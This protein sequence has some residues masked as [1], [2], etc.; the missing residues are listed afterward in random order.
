[1]KKFLMFSIACLFVSVSAFAQTKT[2]TGKIIG[3]DDGLGLPASV[4]VQG[5]TRGV[6]ADIDGNYSIA[7]DRGQTLVISAI[8]YT[9]QEIVIGDANVID[10]TLQVEAAQLTEAVVTALGIR[11]EKKALGYSVQDIKS[12]EL[13]KNKT[14]NP[15]NSLAGKV[16]GVNVTQSSGAAGS[17]AQI[18]LRGGTS[19]DE[20][21]DNQ[22]LFVVDGMI[23]DNST[24]V[25][26]SSGFDGMTGTATTNSNRIMDIN[27]EDIENMSIL[28]GPAAAA[29]Y[30]S[31]AAN[32]VI[33]ITTKKGAEGTVSVD[34]SSKFSTAWANRLPEQ[35]ST[36]GRGSYQVSGQLN[37]ND[38]VVYS[39]WGEKLGS[40]TTRYNNIEDFFQASTIF[41]NTVSVSGGS[42]TG[43]FY[44]SASNF[45]QKGIVPN[46][47][48]VKNTFR[49]N[50]EQKYGKLTLNVG[51]AYSQANTDKTLTSDGLYG[52]GGTGTM[53]AVYRWAR[54]ENMKTW[55]N[56]D[57][58]KYIFPQYL[59][60]NGQ[61]DMNQYPL[62]S[63]VENPYWLINKNK[64]TDQTNRFTGNATAD[65]KV[66]D[67]WNLTYR[68]G[69]DRYTTGNRN[70][71][72]P[73][74]ELT[75]ADYQDGL[76][77]ENQLDFQYLSYNF[78]SNMDKTFGDFS[79]GLLLGFSEEETK[80]EQNYRMAIRP[81]VDGF[82]SFS[83]STDENK[84]LSQ[85]QSKTRMRSFYGE[86]RASY[87]NIAYLTVTGRGD[88]N[89]TLY[90]PL[91][92]D[93]NASYFYPSVG[94]SFIFSEVLPDNLKSV[95]SF[96]KVRAS[97]AQVGKGTD[98]YATST[99][100]WPFTTF[101]GGLTGTANFWY[102]GNP[103]LKP[104]MT[105]SIE[106]GLEMRFL[107]GRLGFDYTYYSNKSTDLILNPRT[108]QATGYIFNYTNIGE[109]YNKGMELSITGQPLKT[110]DWTWDMAL[111]IAG[112]RGT[113]GEIHQSLPILYVTSVQVGRAK[114]ASY[115]NGV[116]MAISGSKWNRTDDGKV[117]LNQYG[118]PTHD[119]ATATA[120]TYYIGN[121]EPKFTGGFNNSIR[122]KGW[123]LSFLFEFR[124]GGDVY[125]G[126]ELWLTENGM[127]K[128]TEN[129]ETLTIDGVINT[130]TATDPVYENKT[131]TFNADQTY[132]MANGP[133][134]GKYII[135]QYWAS[136]YPRESAYFKTKTNWLRLRSV[137]LS[138]TLPQELLAK[139][140]FIKGCTVS[141]TGTNLLL[142]T[143]YKGL[144]PEASAAGSGIGGSSSVGIEYCNVPATAG[145]SFGINL[146][147]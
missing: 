8:G 98:P 90:S 38:Y 142:I 84:R 57:G 140:K 131:F 97:W 132:Q 48:Y 21:R 121:R 53:N 120:N 50:G 19:L 1:M 29:L 107:K 63:F 34:F 126:T 129:R 36:Y 47:G 109:V 26:G 28:K 51:A 65:F 62:G 61:R 12:E 96:G 32:G 119:D 54:N 44:F 141:V 128:L 23:Y 45:D 74:G 88:K 81:S 4:Q 127:S 94:G 117:I 6:S 15:L 104:E 69:I 52:S 100:L 31:R 110:K 125:N 91:T 17:G 144:D 103:Y 79:V 56:S 60:V 11:K 99:T 124:V 33:I 136:E 55:L 59:D 80:T 133:Q 137:S 75:K 13:L 111:N 18:I 49:F 134:S 2:V 146:K 73:G 22:P 118:M 108:S 83:V 37:P 112:N 25:V 68:A 105:T 43:S 14:A 58:S 95:I 139:V 16:A 35:Q 115:E 30:G 87:K 114:A 93:A 3:S 42:K 122:Y 145:L 27:P 67:W 147:F 39:S 130:G 64:M 77:S 82:P 66:F 89:S 86:V 20:S 70:I 7:V 113:V 123:N 85:S 78:M 40:G 116:F 10:V 92:G 9:A 24:S 71:I 138:Y 41:D 101:I 76:L 106:L 135:Q 143:N 5:T 46:T 72:A 102:R